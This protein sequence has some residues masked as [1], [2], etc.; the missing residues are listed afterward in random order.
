L[1]TITTTTITITV[2]VPELREGI[3]LDK[4]LTVSGDHHSL[5]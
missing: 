1:A 4:K 5:P 3:K 2:T